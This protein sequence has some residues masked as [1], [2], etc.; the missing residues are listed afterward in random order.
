MKVKK[1][2]AI[3]FGGM[4]SEHEVSCVSVVN[5][6]GGFDKDK[7]DISLIGITKDGKWILADSIESI[8]NGKWR[9]GNN[10][11][12]ISPDRS[13]PGVLILKEDTYEYRKIDVIFPV[14]HGKF[15]EDGTIQGL[16]ELSGI[17][18]VGCGVL[19]SAASMDKISTKIFVEQLGIR[20][21]DYVADIA[22]DLSEM[23]ATIQKV[24]KKLGYP[25]FVKPSNAGSSCGVSKA[26]DRAELE[27]AI[28]LAKEHDTRVLIEEMISGHEVE[29]GVL[30]GNEVK[31]SRVG[32]VV[33]AAEFY[34]YD[35]KYNN[36]ESKTVIDPVGIPEEAKEKVRKYAVEI[37]KAVSGFG[38]S[39]VDFFVEN[40]TNDVVFNEIN[41]LPG[42]TNISMYPML[43]NDMGLS[44]NQLIDRL[45]DTA[46]ER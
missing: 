9:E 29:C 14:L 41:T 27:A 15:G 26:C 34:D 45:I 31:A 7:Y 22:K 3:I 33:A 20:Q 19:S 35:A 11:A 28:R 18:Y 17:P 13:K 1:Q 8:E 2:V 4:S 6:A 44:T 12:V 21:A 46:F 10:L 42:F 40:E 39:R 24:E 37:F 23:D 43:W 32:E 16:F 5:V 30:G 36:A 38:L 25:V